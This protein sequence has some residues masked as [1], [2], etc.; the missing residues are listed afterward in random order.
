M[1]K[2][3]EEPKIYI[4]LI[5]I[6]GFILL[7]SLYLSF[8]FIKSK[9]FHSYPFYNMI[10]FSLMVSFATILRI[11]PMGD[12][13]ET[14]ST[15]ETINAFFI[16]CFDKLIIC[17]LSMQ[18]LTCYFGIVK[19]KFYFSYEKKI[20]FTT[21]IT[22]LIVSTSLA[23]IYI[24]V[25]DVIEIGIYCYCKNTDNQK[26]IESIFMGVYFCINILCT[27]IVLIYISNRKREVKAGLIPD[28]DYNRYYK[29]ILILFFLNALIFVISYILNY[30][31]FDRNYEDLIYIIACFTI[32][33]VNSL[34]KTVYKETLKIFCKKKYEEK[35]PKTKYDNINDDEEEEEDEDTRMKRT[36]TD[37]F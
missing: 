36:L 7:I 19:T 34:N 31:V 15:T 29:K 33:L 18:S 2:I 25:F 13:E 35:F 26:I 1:E 14:C 12:T 22:S 8:L 20:F 27:I 16:I 4:P 10:C 9:S 11:I 32:T 28:I 17:T 24:L 5:T 23:I 30:D 3:R 37:N 6:N 21:L